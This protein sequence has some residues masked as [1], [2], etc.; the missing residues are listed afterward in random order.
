MTQR[1]PT[2]RRSNA[3]PGDFPF[4]V[5]VGETDALWAN[6][7][8]SPTERHLV[9]TPVQL[10]RRNVKRRLR[11]DARPR[12]EFAFARLFDVARDL[13]GAARKATDVEPTT[14]TL[15]RI[16]RLALTRRI[17]REESFPAETLARVVGAP[18]A[19][20]TERI[21]RARTSLSVVMGFH[22]DRLAAL[23]AVADETMGAAAADAR[24]LLEGLATVDGVE[25]EIHGQ[26]D[27]LLRFPDGSWAVE[28]AKI[29]LADDDAAE[30]RCQLQLATYEWAFRRQVG[31][32]T[33]VTSRLSTF[34][35]SPG[36]L[37]CALNT[38]A[39]EHYLRRFTE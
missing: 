29:A 11:E 7:G 17:L 21:E 18:A 25:V 39:V 30:A 38:A 6:A 13:A 23:R 26:A 5:R 1:D 32:A 34:D 37:E 10:H 9:V 14:E 24:D 3:R 28:D 2:T 35:V 27:F 33:A 4:A 16:D 20:R 19:D 12:S 15:D 31:T 8:R 36:A 22:S